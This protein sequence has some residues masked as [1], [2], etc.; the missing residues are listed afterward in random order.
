MRPTAGDDALAVSDLLWHA[1][2]F[3]RQRDAEHV[4]KLFSGDPNSL[5]RSILSAKARCAAGLHLCLGSLAAIMLLF[6]LFEVL[7][8]VTDCARR[9]FWVARH[10]EE[11]LNLCAVTLRRHRH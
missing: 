9:A 6:L 11:V 5:R 3:A 1:Q 2:G 7:D 10:D 8:V 4:F